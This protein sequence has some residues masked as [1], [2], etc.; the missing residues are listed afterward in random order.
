MTVSFGK[1]WG[2]DNASTTQ[3][4][5]NKY[6]KLTVLERIGRAKN[7]TYYMCECECGTKVARA[8][9][10]LRENRSGL[11]CGCIYD[12]EQKQERQQKEAERIIKVFED[13]AIEK[14]L[15]IER[16]RNSSEMPRKLVESLCWDCIRSA[17]PPSLQC[18][19]DKNK[20]YGMPEGAESYSKPCI[21]GAVIKVVTSCPLYLSVRDKENEEL[22]EREREKNK[23]KLA[24][25]FYGKINAGMKQAR[26]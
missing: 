26:G 18:I 5:G 22:L 14:Q 10:M 19:R 9:S 8:S 3:K 1:K 23:R 15:R 17:A 12:G 13:V 21:Y 20:G 2:G 11:H 16:E 25:E 7:N 6:G 4:I 24:N